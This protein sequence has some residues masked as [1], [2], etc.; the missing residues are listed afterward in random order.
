MGRR[1][2]VWPRK[3]TGQFYCTIG[4]QQVPL[5]GDKDAAER[6]YHRLKSQHQEAAKVGMTLE[7]LCDHFMD[8]IERECEPDTIEMYTRTLKRFMASVGKGIAPESIRT[9]DV[10]AWVAKNTRWNP[11]TK[12]RMITIVKRLYSWGVQEGHIEKNPIEGMEKPTALI[13]QKILTASQVETIFGLIKDQEFKDLLTALKD[14]GCRPGE[15]YKLTAERVDL[16]AGTW[17]VK[18][19]TRK[20]TGQEYRTIYL[21]PSMVELS[22]RLV[23]RHGSGLVFRNTQGGAWNRNNVTRRMGKLKKQ[24]G[25]GAEMVAYSFRHLFV[26]DALERGVD[27]TV[28]AELVG[29]KS[30]SMILRVYSKLGQRVEHLKRCARMISAP[31]PTSPT[32]DV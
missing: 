2:H 26:T 32:T 20:K 28:L 31:K 8:S 6:E 11:T 14:T 21:S 13:R 18:N 10:S 1:G 25:F 19:K 27:P 4:G 7:A 12:N 16:D 23:S 22:R 9:K 15:A 3:G 24:T 30:L 17:T 29:H 5:G